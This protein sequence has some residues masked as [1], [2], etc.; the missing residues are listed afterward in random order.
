MH[1]V[2]WLIAMVAR[3]P[4]LKGD[5]KMSFTKLTTSQTQFLESFLR[6]TGREL[7]SVQAKAQFGIQN[8]RARMTDIRQANLVVK[9]RVNYAGRTAYSITARDTNGSRARVFSD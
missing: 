4:T 6:G 7:T 5:L 2:L 9:T 8:L 1:N 3:I